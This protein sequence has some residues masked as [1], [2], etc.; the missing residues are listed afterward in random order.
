[1][2]E[3][4]TQYCLEK[5]LSSVTEHNRHAKVDW[6]MQTA[7]E[8]TTGASVLERIT[9]LLDGLPVESLLVI[10]QLLKLLRDNG[11][12]QIHDKSLD[13]GGAQNVFQSPTV[14]VPASSLNEL[15]G[16]VSYDGDALRDSEAL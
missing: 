3:D 14:V 5:L 6:D 10:E 8:T 16:I 12:R 11:Q 7:P 15:I 4:N 2:S 13:N 9:S 1:M